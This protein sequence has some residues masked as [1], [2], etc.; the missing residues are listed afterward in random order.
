M[1]GP[2]ETE[3]ACIKHC[4]PLL[5]RHAPSL[6]STKRRAGIL[7]LP[8]PCF[9]LT[10]KAGVRHARCD[11]LRAARIQNRWRMPNATEFAADALV[12]LSRE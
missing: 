9:D 4:V 6:L 12:F 3:A 1:R 7:L 10:G 2:I 5:R 8:I 11:S